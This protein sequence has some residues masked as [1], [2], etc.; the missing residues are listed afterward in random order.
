MTRWLSAIG[1]A[2]LLPLMSSV[3]ATQAGRT[4]TTY[5]TKEEFAARRAKILEAIGPEGLA[6]IQGAPSVHASAIFRQS[7]EFFYVSGVVVPQAYLLLDGKDRRSILYLPGRDERRA[8]TEGELLTADEPAKAVAAT[9]IDEV[10]PLDALAAD[11]RMRAQGHTSV[12]VPY[13]PAEGLS[14]SRDG[15]RRRNGDVARD[16]WDGRFAREVHFRELLRARGPAVEIMDLSPALDAM[17]ALK[18]P[19]EIA[20]MDR[21][22]RIGGEAILEAMRSTQPGVMEN[23]LDAVAQLIY[24]RHGAQGEAYRAIVASGPTALNAHHRAAERPLPD[25]ELVIMD[26]C[27]DISYYRCDIT[28]MWPVNGTFNA[29]QREHAARAFVDGYRRSSERPNAGLG[30]GIGMSTHDMGSGSG[31]LKPG[32][33]F[34]IEPQFRIPEEG[35]FIRLED[36]VI[37][38][39]DRVEIQSDWLPRD[40]PR[41]EK[42]V[43]EPG[44]LQSYPKITFETAPQTKR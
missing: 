36:M 8:Q 12:F 11:L 40:M 42:V 7:N 20:V 18:S 32:M 29:W 39:A 35:I 10:K 44:L 15:A 6:V 19:A 28:R 31:M 30:H 38:H 2:C 43:A 1:M 27:P 24:V 5:F 13:Q 25:G 4:F 33:T 17:R 9:G 34:T 41:V 14:E 16:P 21:A 23:E 37:I 22:S 3:G 26:Y